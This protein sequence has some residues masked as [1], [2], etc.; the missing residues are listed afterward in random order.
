LTDTAELLSLQWTQIRY[1]E[2]GEPR[3]ILLPAA[4]TKTAKAR[5][6]PVGARLRAELSMRR[7][8]P[9]G[10]QLPGTAHVFGNE[11]GERIAG[12]RRRWE[13]AVLLAHGHKPARVRGKLT[14]DSRAAL[15]TIDL[16]F[17]D[18]RREFASRLLESSADLHDVQMFLGHANVSQTS[19]Y[20]KSTPTRLERALQKLESVGFAHDSHTAASEPPTGPEESAAKPT[21]S[22]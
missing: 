15:R 11:I 5:A 12:L 19:T 20:L 7:H 2:A 1:D 16:H 14:S 10:R 3:S 8:G 6:I 13:D 4:K 22:H 18:L 17:R 9:D 21:V